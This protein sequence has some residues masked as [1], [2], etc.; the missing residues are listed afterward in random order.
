MGI[1][2]T[3][4][5]FF[6]AIGCAL[7]LTVMQ[8]SAFLVFSIIFKTFSLKSN[9]KARGEE[10]HKKQANPKVRPETRLNQE[11]KWIAVMERFI[12]HDKLTSSSL[13]G[14]VIEVTLTGREC[15]RTSLVSRTFSFTPR[16]WC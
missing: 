9:Q 4:K 15:S 16:L 1:I 10:A 3:G 13:S 8:H 5:T 14:G 6:Y 12:E 11:E 7:L 2:Y